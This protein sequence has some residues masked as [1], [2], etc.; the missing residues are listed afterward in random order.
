MRDKKLYRERKK[1]HICVQCG[2]KLRKTYQKVHCPDCLEDLK[3]R[4]HALDPEKQNSNKRERYAYR[5]DVL[6]VCPRCGRKP[7][8]G[9]TLCKTCLSLANSGAK[10]K[11]K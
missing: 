6:G 7:A 2:K 9:R 4:Q 11:K 5:R 8:K 1:N 10:L 3:A